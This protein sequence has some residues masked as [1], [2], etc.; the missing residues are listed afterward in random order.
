MT[1]AI[2]EKFEAGVL[3]AERLAYSYRDVVPERAVAVISI[4]PAL[5]AQSELG[6]PDMQIS[7]RRTLNSGLPDVVCPGR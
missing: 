3:T 6:A 7:P 5:P 4:R 2:G 1:T